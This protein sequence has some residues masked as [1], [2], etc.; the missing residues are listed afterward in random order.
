MKTVKDFGDLL[1]AEMAMNGPR[2]Y[3][4][5]E[6]IESRDAEIHAM[7]APVVEALRTISEKCPCDN[8]GRGCPCIDVADNALA[9]IKGVKG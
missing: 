6:L 2:S 4:F 7:Y 1:C 9:A 8:D 5:Y 3:A